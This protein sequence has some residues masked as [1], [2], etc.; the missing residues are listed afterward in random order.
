MIGTDVSWYL[1]QAR[2]LTQGT[3]GCEP[4]LPLELLVVGQPTSHVGQAT[5][6][7]HGDCGRQAL[8]AAVGSRFSRTGLLRPVRADRPRRRPEAERIPPAVFIL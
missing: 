3:G 2:E 4:D 6:L 7:S 1:L 5:R 8:V